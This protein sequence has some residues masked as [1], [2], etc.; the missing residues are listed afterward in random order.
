MDR[1]SAI[2]KR[3]LEIAADYDSLLAVVALGSSV[4]EYASADCYSD[5]DLLLVCRDPGPWLTGSL[6]EQL[7]EVRISFVEHT[8]AGGME[9]RILYSGSL[10]VD[11]I[12]LTPEQMTVA[13][14]SGVAAEILGRGYRVLHD[15]VGVADSLR[16][17]V[18]VSIPKPAMT[19]AEF[20]NIVNDFWFHTVWAAKKLL[21]GELWT[22]KM[23]I[24]A[25]LKERLLKI[26]ELKK[27]SSTDVWHNGRFLEKWAGEEM[28]VALG[29]CFARY[30]RAEMASAL[31]ETAQLFGRT[32]QEAAQQQRFSY[33][34]DVES[35]AR[36]LLS[37]YL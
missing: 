27:V 19:E 5:L 33:P 17:N 28:V 13:L 9:R 23:C 15:R 8:F 20:T 18:R 36:A 14:E 7:G 34:H 24:D 22:A 26:L 2:R 30:E 11:L 16:E 4:R 3:L 29:G 6:P 31:R 1:Y 10:D 35:Y 37:E 21:R 25:Y 12:L 32:A